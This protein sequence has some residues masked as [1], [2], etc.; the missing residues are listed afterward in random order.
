MCCSIACFYLLTL[1][2]FFSVSSCDTSAKSR[3]LLS[4]L[5]FH[6]PASLTHTHTHRSTPTHTPGGVHFDVECL[7]SHRGGKMQGIQPSWNSVT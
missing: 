3:V 5:G 7:I 2:A 6:P 1:Q 4:K